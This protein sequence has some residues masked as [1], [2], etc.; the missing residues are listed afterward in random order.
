MRLL[1]IL[2]LTSFLL[3]FHTLSAQK[4]IYMDAK[5]EKCKK[6]HAVYYRL[7]LGKDASGLIKVED[8]YKDGTLQMSGTYTS[9]EPSIREGAFK[10]Y[11]KKGA[12]SKECTYVKDSLDG[13]YQDW[14][15][16][17]KLYEKCTYVMSRVQG[18][19]TA[20]DSLG[21]IKAEEHYNRGVLDSAKTYHMDGQLASKRIFKDDQQQESHCYN[22]AGKDTVC[23]P[24]NFKPTFK[25]PGYAS[26]EAYFKEKYVQ[27]NTSKIKDRYKVIITIDRNGKL[28][29]LRVVPK[30]VKAVGDEINRVMMS[31]SEYFTPAYKRGLAVK[32]KLTFDINFQWE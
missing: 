23:N 5:W 18:E 2:S 32:S 8:Y 29:D 20:Y 4:K 6:K 15:P 11:T 1:F 12:L 14:Y 19:L 10:Y 27:P 26:H 21:H 24:Y 22:K 9:L 25:A 7:V 28:I 16:N 13:P 30:P 3:Q 17:G 31:A